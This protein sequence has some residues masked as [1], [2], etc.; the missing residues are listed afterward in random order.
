MGLEA[1]SRGAESA[2]LADSAKDA[3]EVIKKNVAKTHFENDA[4]VVFSNYKDLLKRQRAKFGLVFL[5]PPYASDFLEDS[6]KLLDE[7]R[8]LE[9]NATLVCESDKP[10]IKFDG[11]C[12]EIKTQKKYGIAYITIL[13]YKRGEPK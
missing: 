2:V 10:D 1:V 5:D 11:E 3:V 13:N 4:T 6:L 8:I 12:Y 7:Y 9:D